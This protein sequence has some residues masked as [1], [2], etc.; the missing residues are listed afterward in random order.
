M[1][2]NEV[3]PTRRT[4]LLETVLAGEMAVRPMTTALLPSSYGSR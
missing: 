3:G 1:V 2:D 4:A